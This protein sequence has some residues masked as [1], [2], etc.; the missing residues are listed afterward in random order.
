MFIDSL[1]VEFKIPASAYVDDLK[2]IANLTHLRHFLTQANIDRVNEWSVSRGMLLFVKKC[3]VV[4]CGM[5]NP[6]HSYQCGSIDLPEADSVA[7]LGAIRSADYTFRE[8]ILMVAQRECQL[9]GQSFR[10]IQTCDPAFMACIY[11]SY[12][13]S[14]LNCAS[15][16]WSLYLRQEVNELEF[17]QR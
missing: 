7:D 3:L 2:F 4:L 9:V 10:T 16:I 11:R 13:L 1:L 8:H 6:R 14:G 12:I 17:V 5:S 15:P